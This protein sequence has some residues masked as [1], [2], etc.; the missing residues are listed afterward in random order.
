MK[1]LH[2]NAGNEYGGGLF[3][4]V[5]LLDKMKENEEASLL[6]FEEGPVAKEAR[7]NG[8][9]VFTLGQTSKFDLRFLSKLKAFIIRNEFDVVHSHGP[10]AN[11]YVNWIINKIKPIKWVVTVHSHPYLDFKGRGIIGKIFQKLNVRSYFNADAIISVSKEI[12]SIVNKHRNNSDWSYVIH[13]GI[14][15]RDIKKKNSHETEVL[16][17]LAVGRLEKVKGFDLLID[18]LSQ[19]PPLSENW[20]LIICGEG[21]EFQNLKNLTKYYSLEGNIT[22]EGWV[23]K[24]RLDD[25]FK[26][27]DLYIL[28]SLS[29]SFPLVALEAMEFSTPVVATNV[30]DVI[31]MIPSEVERNI[32]LTEP[33]NSEELKKSLLDTY[34]LWKENKLNTIGNQFRTHAEKFSSAKQAEETVK[35][36]RILLKDK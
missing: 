4:I 35:V 8:I 18:A 3:H 32:F 34:K 26:Q 21:S 22:F 29:E 15:F 24:K 7:E 23:D 28:S 27:A 33:N 17:M 36:Y 20:E 30:G 6:V 5:S 14:E 11:V 9:K 25:F 1:I 13:N 31:E 12:D 10:R 16:T 19:L 2:I